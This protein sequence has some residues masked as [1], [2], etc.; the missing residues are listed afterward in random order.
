MVQDAASGH[1]MSATKVIAAAMVGNALEF[2]D[3]FIYG[4]LAIVIKHEFGDEPVVNMRVG[5]SD[6]RLY[7]RVGVPTIVCGL[8]PN[9]MGA[10][11]EYVTVEELTGLGRVMAAA[12]FDYLSA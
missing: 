3:L 2:Y 1:K 4:F 11:D 6:A 9:N 12:S 5:A 7:R 8:T 10:A